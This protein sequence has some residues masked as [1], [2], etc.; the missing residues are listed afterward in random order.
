MSAADVLIIGA[1]ASGAVASRR[2]A[3]AGFDVVCL[4]QGER[5][6]PGAY[7]GA[8]DDWELTGLKQWTW[9]P[10]IR[11]ARADYPVEVS[12][13]D[14]DPL[15]FNGVG[16][17]TVQFA[18]Q[19]PRLA[20][21]DFRVRTLDGV[22]DD[23][24]LTYEELQPYYERSDVDF[25][26]SGIGGDPA[27]PPGAEPPLPPLPLPEVATDIARA[28]NRL[29][30]HWW[31]G[32]NAIAS[33]RYR[34]RRPCVQRGTCAWGC[35]EGA[36]GS[37]D[38]THW[39]DAERFGAR[40]VTGARVR[41]ITLDARGLATG[42]IYV[43]RDGHERHQPASVVLVA[44]NGIG[45][46]RLLLLSTST[47]FPDGL[48][49][50]SGLV[51]KRLMMHPF[52][53]VIGL[54][55]RHWP[56]WQGHWGQSLQCMEF[57]ETDPRRDFVR[58]AKWGLQPTGGPLGAALGFGGDPVWGTALHERVRTNL[59]HSIMWGII[60]EDL[61]DDANRVTL[62]GELADPDGVPA[63]RIQYRVSE[64]SR[65]LLS[66]QAARAA[67]SLS[68]AGAYETVVTPQVRGTGWH[69]LGTARMGDDP[70]CSVV[71]RWCRS[72]DVENLYVIDGSVFVTSGG[73]NPTATIS[74][75]ALRATERLIETRRQQRVP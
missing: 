34:G 1:G 26:V 5:S 56:S 64:N 7:R 71:D 3:E 51:G 57:Y 40:L 41:Q 47:G 66:F 68:E 22:A 23:W 28:H 58:G 42:A 21:S 69:L 37:T 70:E 30:W 36:K 50:R 11:R 18:A 33:R 8:Y 72:H 60:G 14:I 67:E 9:D 55:D 17:S 44:A 27:Y 59:G 29:G 73:V 61:P 25:G 2:L 53:T 31:P 54:F 15:M 16:G 38:Q 43:D 75:L 48:A 32:T 74:A 39:P 63:P 35:G 10:N 20:P 19:W 65:R 4:E 46:P 12:E 24:P 45:T 6:D 49:N 62:D 13:S 52:G